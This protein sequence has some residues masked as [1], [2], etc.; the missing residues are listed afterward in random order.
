MRRSTQPRFVEEPGIA[1]ATQEGAAPADDVLQE[2]P[3]EK[4]RRPEQPADSGFVVVQSARSIDGIPEAEQRMIPAG[5][6]LPFPVVAPGQP[7]GGIST[8]TSII[9]TYIPAMPARHIRIS[10]SRS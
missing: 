6:R 10:N 3:I 8:T 4:Q 2:R 9:G 5:R 1:V 7:L